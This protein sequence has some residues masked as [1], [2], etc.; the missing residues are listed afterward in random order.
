MQNYLC[1]LHGPLSS[2]ATFTEKYAIF[3][4][5]RVQNSPQLQVLVITRT[6]YLDFIP[7]VYNWSYLI[8]P[9]STL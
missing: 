4:L 6:T 2:N 8:P 9:K 1:Q 7:A 3:F 5:M